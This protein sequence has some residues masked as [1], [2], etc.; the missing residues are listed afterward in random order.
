MEAGPRQQI[1][2]SEM[3]KDEEHVWN[4]IVTRHGLCPTTFRDAEAWHFGDFVLSAG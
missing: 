1:R 3:I 2:L 4:E